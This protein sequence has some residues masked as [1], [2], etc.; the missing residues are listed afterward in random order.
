MY[1]S[2]SSAPEIGVPANA[3]SSARLRDQSYLLVSL[4]YQATKAYQELVSGRLWC[5]EGGR[6]RECKR[7][8]HANPGDS[9]CFR[10]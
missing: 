3:R 5:S 1:S 7:D 9:G 2:V 8:P 4:T 10:K 6:T